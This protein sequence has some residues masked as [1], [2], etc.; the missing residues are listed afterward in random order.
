MPRAPKSLTLL[1]VVSAVERT[2]AAFAW[3]M[4]ATDQRF[5]AMN[6]RCLSPPS[7]AGLTKS[8]LTSSA[9]ATKAFPIPRGRA[10]GCVFKI[11][12]PWTSGASAAP[13]RPGQST[14]SART[15]A[16]ARRFFIG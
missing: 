10:P 5:V 12:A 2:N 13:A 11:A 9:T 16:E 7:P 15:A 8:V 6:S 1:D 3:R 14:S 4:P